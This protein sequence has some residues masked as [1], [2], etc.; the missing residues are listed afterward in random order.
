MISGMPQS[1]NTFCIA[2]ST[3]FIFSPDSC[4]ITGKHENRSTISMSVLSLKTNRSVA[5]VFQVTIRMSIGMYSS[6]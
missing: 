4:L 2:F 6:F 5:I 1:A 3:V